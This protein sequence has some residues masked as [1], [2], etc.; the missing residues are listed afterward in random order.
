MMY[1]I[2]PMKP[3]QISLSDLEGRWYIV[4]SNFPMW[5]K[6]DKTSPSLNYTVERRG[7]TTGLRDEV[8]SWKR[9]KEQS[10]LGFD[11]PLDSTNTRFVWR[12]N[13]LLRLLQSAWEIV[14]MDAANEW[15]IIHF[16]KT[17]FTPEGYD[18][19]A[20]SKQLSAHSLELIRAKLSEIGI[21]TTL[22]AIS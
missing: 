21:N 2:T 5:L 15:A 1:K 20:R 8:L 16:E 9:G 22:S 4:Q 12:G 18:V 6:G 14:Y 7:T 3:H 10:I 17:M 13:G 11:T 19:I